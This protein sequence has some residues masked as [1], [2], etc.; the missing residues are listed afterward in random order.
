[1]RTGICTTDFEHGKER[2]STDKLFEKIQGIGFECVQF[3]FSSVTECD[4]T[5]S[6]LIEIPEIITS[7]AIECVK[8][9]STKYSLPIEV[10]NGTFNMAHPDV[11][12]RQEG[13]KRL[14]LLMK[15]A[16]EVDAKYI[17][18]CSGTRNKSHLWRYSDE[19]DS[20]DAWN[21]M[22]D[23]IQ[24][25]VDLA[26][27]YSITLAIESEVSNVIDTPENALR[28]MN[29][30]GSDRL[31]MILDCANLF[32]IGEAHEE[33]VRQVI[34]HAFEVFGDDIVIVHGKDIRAGNGI[35]FCET[36]LGIVDFR[37][38]AELLKKYGYTGDMFLHGIYY[39]DDMPRALNYWR[40]A[41]KIG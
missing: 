12:V 26:E 11:S 2:T 23:T 34:G 31:K 32:H 13:L 16:V 17:S 25:A 18:L 36:G 4:Y 10:I 28:V 24:S 30:I 33:N 8:K 19:N 3:A 40:Q 9:A 29:E 22:F 35:E 21:D 20:E 1:M 5:T 39:E 7:E 41:E 37:F 6:G 38:T 27:K 14:K 15:A